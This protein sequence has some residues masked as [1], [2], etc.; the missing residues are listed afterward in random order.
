MKLRL[1]ESDTN[2]GSRRPL[3]SRASFWAVAFSGWLIRSG[4]TA[5]SISVMSVVFSLGAGALFT[6]I[7]PNQ[8]S[9]FW[10]PA[11]ALLIQLRLI[12]NLMDGMVA[13]EGG[14]KSP[15]GDL[16]NEVPDR[17]ADLLIL[18]PLGLNVSV[19]PLGIHLGWAVGTLAVATAY[20]RLQGASLTGRHEFC[21]PMAKPHRMALVTIACLLLPFLPNEWNALQ[22]ILIAMATGEVV[23]LWRRLSRIASLLRKK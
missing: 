14:K 23:T 8:V 17:L 3:K 2:P 9:E 7:A 19:Q 15:V 18:V 5:N 1:V 22:W 13:I 10:F 20:V 6:A 21:G 11:G 16:F 12:C 4:V